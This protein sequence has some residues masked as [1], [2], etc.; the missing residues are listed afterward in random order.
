MR[1]III[2]ILINVNTIYCQPYFIL[3]LF[4]SPSGLSFPPFVHSHLYLIYSF[5]VN[6]IFLPS[7]LAF[8]FFFTSWINSLLLFSG[9]RE[10]EAAVSCSLFSDLLSLLILFLFSLLV[11]YLFLSS[12]ISVFFCPSLTSFSFVFWSPPLSSCLSF[13]FSF[14]SH[15]TSPL[16]SFLSLTSFRFWPSYISS[17]FV[18][19]D[20]VYSL[21]L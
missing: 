20:S 1:D 7:S 14:P 21:Y 15:P 2:I 3:S 12:S 17:P 5:F 6:Q 11:L 8:F 4:F 10:W 9:R 16:L 13:S 18:L 19:L